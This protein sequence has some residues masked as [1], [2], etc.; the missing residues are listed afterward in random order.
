MATVVRRISKVLLFIG[1]FILSVKYVHTYPQPMTAHQLDVLL[2]IC[3]KLGIHDPDDFYIPAM[4]VAELAVTII[5]YASMMR[6]WRFYRVK[7]R[8]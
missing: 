7:Q 2:R 1:L 8:G 4:R 6:I 5:V 3:E